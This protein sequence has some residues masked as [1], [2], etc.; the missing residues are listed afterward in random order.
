MTG[1]NIFFL[2]LCVGFVVLSIYGLR[3]KSKDESKNKDKSD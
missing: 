1:E 2:S 3:N